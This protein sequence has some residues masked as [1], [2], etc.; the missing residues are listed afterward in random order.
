[1]HIAVGLL[2]LTTLG[3]PVSFL[4]DQFEMPDGF[5]IYKVASGELCGGSYDITFDGD[6]R[7]LVGDGQQV[8]RLIDDD[9]DGVYDRYEVIARGLGGRG[10]QGLAVVGDSEGYGILARVGIGGLPGK[11]A[12]GR[13]E[14]RTGRQH[15]RAL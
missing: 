10:P 9:H 5:R 7:L 8:R 15:G 1:M 3:A 4:E 12:G 11:D 6:G 13:V 2:A 14:A